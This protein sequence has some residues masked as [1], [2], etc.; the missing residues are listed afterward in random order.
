MGKGTVPNCGQLYSLG[1]LI[2]VWEGVVGQ[3]AQ[4]L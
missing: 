3:K 2:W 1:N 4:G